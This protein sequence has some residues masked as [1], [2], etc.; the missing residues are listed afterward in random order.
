MRFY[1]RQGVDYGV[2]DAAKRAALAAARQTSD[3][4]ALRG[5]QAVDSSRGEPAFVFSVGDLT[6]AHVLEA[7][8]TKSVLTR[9]YEEATGEQHYDWLARDTVAA[10]V[11]DLACCGARPL[12]VNAYFASGGDGWYA[13]DGRLAQLVGGWRDACLEA[14]ATWGGGESPSLPDL[15][16]GGELELAGSAVG[17]LPPATQPLLGQDLAAGDVIVLVASSGLHANGASAARAVAAR[18][19]DGLRTELPGGGSFGEHVL[20]PSLLYSRLVEALLEERLEV[21]YLSHVT[22]HG[23][24]KVMRANREL[25]YRL[26]DLPAVPPVL[27]F[28]AEQAGMDDREAYGTFNMGAGFAIYCRPAAAERVVR[29]AASHGHAALVA[30]E[31]EAGPRAVVLAPLGVRF[32]DEELQL[33]ERGR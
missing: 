22:G 16:V 8:G 26:H 4:L 15:V 11:N 13:R 23:L 18:L 7:L 21:T 10:V 17:V 24:R 19:P 2:L 32:D 9:L 29:L 3:Q 20:R 6:L 25:T 1:E 33:R 31:V 28:L 27:R 5:G 12:V 30:G 14:G